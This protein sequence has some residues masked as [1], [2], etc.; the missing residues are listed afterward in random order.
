MFIFLLD[1]LSTRTFSHNYT[2]HLCKQSQQTCT[3]YSQ[4]TCNVRTCSDSIWLHN[5]SNCKNYQS[6]MIL[7]YPLTYHEKHMFYDYH[8]NI[9]LIN[10]ESIH[11]WWTKMMLNLPSNLKQARK[12]Q[13]E[14]NSYNSLLQS[15]IPIKI[16]ILKHYNNNKRI[17]KDLLQANIRQLMFMKSIIDYCVM[18]YAKDTS[19]SIKFDTTKQCL[20]CH[21]QFYMQMLSSNKY[22]FTNQILQMSQSMSKHNIVCNFCLRNV[23]RKCNTSDSQYIKQLVSQIKDTTCAWVLSWFDMTL[24]EWRY[25]MI[26]QMTQQGMTQLKI[27]D[28]DEYNPDTTIQLDLRDMTTHSWVVCFQPTLDD[29]YQQNIEIEG[30]NEHAIGWLEAKNKFTNAWDIPVRLNSQILTTCCFEHVCNNV[31]LFNIVVNY[32]Q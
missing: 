26:Q 14:L 32:Y 24:G 31:E 3:F 6:S 27:V 15:N 9:D 13:H 20:C 25:G 1:F 29:S 17:N 7:T 28:T 19:V 12:L 11:D 2:C 21:R 18:Y 5:D 10:G 30:T 22:V 16:N 4:I 23:I 8:L